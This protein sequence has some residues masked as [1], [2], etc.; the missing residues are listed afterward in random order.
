MSRKKTEKLTIQ[1]C[2]IKYPIT[3]SVIESNSDLPKGTL[4]QIMHKN[5]RRSPK[6]ST[7][8]KIQEGLH[9]IGKGMTQVELIRNKD[10]DKG[11]I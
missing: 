9:A 6:M 7:L 10:E 8:K 3:Y 5:S 2:V 11:E 4:S 1:E